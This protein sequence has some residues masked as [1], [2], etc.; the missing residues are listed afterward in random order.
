MIKNVV[1]L[2]EEMLVLNLFGLIF[3][4]ALHWE[5]LFRQLISSSPLLSDAF[6]SSAFFDER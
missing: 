1:F 2:R 3:V 5:D 6:K 4:E